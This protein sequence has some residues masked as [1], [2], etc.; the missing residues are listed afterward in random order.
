MKNNILTALFFG[1][2]L[3]VS[4]Q[5]TKIGYVNG[6]EIFNLMPEKQKADT[7]LTNYVTE[8]ENEIKKMQDEYVSKATD[9]KETESGMSELIKQTKTEELN[10]LSKRIQDF[11]VSA[12]KEI[13]KK[14]IELYTP[15]REKFDQAL[16]K[17]A[18]QQG[19]KFI[20]DNSQGILLYSEESDDASPFL[21]KEL[22]I[23]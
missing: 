11:Q 15:V 17:I 12:Q 8:F 7:V 2:A 22:G 3:T 6:T 20:I 1:L 9:F 13:Q 19:Y 23:K 14:Q 21:K 5:K 16:K 18:S 10:T 4:A